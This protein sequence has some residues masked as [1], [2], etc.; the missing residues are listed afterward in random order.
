MNAFATMLFHLSELR[1]EPSLIAKL[2]TVSHY[3]YDLDYPVLAN[4]NIQQEPFIC[5]NQF[6]L[7]FQARKFIEHLSTNLPALLPVKPSNSLRS[8]LSTPK[9][10]AHQHRRIIMIEVCND[11]KI[12]SIQE[13]PLRQET[14][15]N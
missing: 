6:L 1:P 2:L 15:A 4:L 3:P 5:S 11:S 12:T 7:L 8:F 10:I 13:V 9:V 14:S